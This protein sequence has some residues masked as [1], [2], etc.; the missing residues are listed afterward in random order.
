MTA[1]GK[2]VKKSKEERANL[3]K[4][5]ADEVI[6]FIYQE[7]TITEMER[8]REALAERMVNLLDIDTEFEGIKSEFKDKI[9]PLKNEVSELT[10]YEKYKARLVTEQC[11]K[12]VDTDAKKLCIYSQDGICVQ[13]RDLTPDEMQL[14]IKPE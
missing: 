13:E 7:F 6:E 12:F 5:N 2:Y 10:G 8:I 3:L 9:T 11:F 1:Q 14:R 4:A